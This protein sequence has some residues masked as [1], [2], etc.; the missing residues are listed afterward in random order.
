MDIKTFL[1]SHQYIIYFISLIGGLIVFFLKIYFKSDES[2]FPKTLYGYSF[3]FATPIIIACLLFSFIQPKL[4]IREAITNKHFIYL[5]I[6]FIITGI[7]YCYDAIKKPYN[8][9]ARGYPKTSMFIIGV[10]CIGFAY[11]IISSNTNDWKNEEKSSPVDTLHTTKTNEFN[12]N[13]TEFTAFAYSIH[14]E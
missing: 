6:Y 5:T 1:L 3:V 13:P 4:E 11:L 2:K 14:L 9:N 10:L 7:S 8:P 12:N